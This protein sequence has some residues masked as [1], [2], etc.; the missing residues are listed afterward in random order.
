LLVLELAVLELGL[1][2]LGFVLAVATVEAEKLALEL[3]HL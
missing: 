1:L 2:V 3:E